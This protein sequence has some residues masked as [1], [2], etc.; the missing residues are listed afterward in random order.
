MQAFARN[1]CWLQNAACVMK[2]LFQLPALASTANHRYAQQVYYGDR[3][4]LWLR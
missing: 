2:E 3:I 4:V 1:A